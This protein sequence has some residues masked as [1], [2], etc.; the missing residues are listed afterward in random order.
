M[1]ASILRQK[2]IPLVT[3]WRPVKIY[4]AII[5]ALVLLGIKVI[6]KFHKFE[7]NKLDWCTE[8]CFSFREWILLY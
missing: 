4:L 2:G 8:P 3:P 1:N 7:V 5:H 6:M